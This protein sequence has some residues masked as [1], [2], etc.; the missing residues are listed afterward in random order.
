MPTI[1]SSLLHLMQ[2]SAALADATRDSDVDDVLRLLMR[3]YPPLTG[4]SVSDQRIRLMHGVSHL[5]PGLMARATVMSLLVDASGHTRSRRRIGERM[6]RAAPR[7]A[8]AADGTCA[9]AGATVGPDDVEQHYGE[10]LRERASRAPGIAGMPVRVATAFPAPQR[11]SDA[12][13]AYD[14]EFETPSFVPA[15]RSSMGSPTQS[16]RVAVRASQRTAATSFGT[17][18]D[19]DAPSDGGSAHAASP[20]ADTE[21]VLPSEASHADAT[22]TA[23][24]AATGTVARSDA[25]VVGRRGD[26]GTRGFGGR[27]ARTHAQ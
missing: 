20:T 8:R 27:V 1:I 18:L 17:Q 26:Y 9:R 14:D 7:D 15:D 12:P 11:A 19:V 16:Q 23:A 25:A 6:L 3:M 24:S 4:A 22:R 2:G 21:F 10:L 5:P 13:S